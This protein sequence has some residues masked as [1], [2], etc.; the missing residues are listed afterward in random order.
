[1]INKIKK[2][3]LRFIVN[4]G[5]IIKSLDKIQSDDLIHLATQFSILLMQVQRREHEDE[6]LALRMDNDDIPF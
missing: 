5:K 4:E 3:D 2:Y 1:M 6:M